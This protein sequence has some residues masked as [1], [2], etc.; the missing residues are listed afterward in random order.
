[1]RI[2][3][4]AFGGDNAPREIV[5]GAVDAL[6]ANQ[7]FE[8]VLVGKQAPIEALLDEFDWHERVE[9]V[10][11]PD[12]IGCDEAPVM[13]IRRKKESSIVRMFN[14][15]AEG[16]VDACMS[17][18]SSGA[19]LAGGIFLIHRLPGV[20]RPAF[21]SVLPTVSGGT[22]VLGDSG[23]NTDCKPEWLLQFA[24]MCDAYKRCMLDCEV[25]RIGLL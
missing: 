12:V 5:K 8:V 2:A 15:L 25:V 22:V 19:I 1:M 9:I 14:L 6:K 3:V 11:A 4:D 23:A 21:C 10:D 13:A 18:G 16:K 24:K 20:D 7:G 17:A